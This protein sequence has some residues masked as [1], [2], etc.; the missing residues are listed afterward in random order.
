M[1]TYQKRR[2]ISAKRHRPVSSGPF[3]WP[4]LPGEIEDEP[5]EYEPDEDEE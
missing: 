1:T 5:D 2:G 3:N 4:V